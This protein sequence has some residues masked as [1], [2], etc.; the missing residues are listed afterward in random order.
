MDV[1]VD[2]PSFDG[3]SSL[4]VRYCHEGKTHDH[5]KDCHECKDHFDRVTDFFGASTVHTN[6]KPYHVP[7]RDKYRVTK[8]FRIDSPNLRDAFQKKCH[9]LSLLGR[10]PNIIPAWHGTDP[11]NVASIAAGNFDIDK[12]RRGA[13]GPGIYH[14]ENPLEAIGYARKIR[15]HGYSA[16]ESVPLILSDLAMGISTNVR[17]GTRSQKT[18]Y[19]SHTSDAMGF[20]V[21]FESS[22]VNPLY[23]V[24]VEKASD[25]SFE[26]QRFQHLSQN[27]T[28]QSPWTTRQPVQQNP[29]ATNTTN[30]SGER[31]FSRNDH[32]VSDPQIHLQTPKHHHQP[33]LLVKSKSFTEEMKTFTEKQE[34]HIIGKLSFD[35]T[36]STDT[37]M[38]AINPFQAWPFQDSQNCQLPSEPSNAGFMFGQ[39]SATF[40]FNR[41]TTPIDELPIPN[42]TPTFSRSN[43]WSNG[44]SRNS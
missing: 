23:V 43:G 35:T 10:N 27:T 3:E 16:R 8:V 13:Y 31:L 22:Q 14:A 9:H 6:G 19:D 40:N 42:N 41:S 18:G 29:F 24:V 30:P 11:K 15:E 26:E 20:K 32:T 17:P 2:A 37:A 33:T 34:F 4:H 25:V 28:N 38:M 39:S 36:T 5:L 12:R 1:D 21:V 7:L 44:W